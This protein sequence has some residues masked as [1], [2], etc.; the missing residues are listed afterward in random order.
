MS[1]FKQRKEKDCLNCGH[2]VEEHYCTHCGQE[3][4]EVKEDALHMIIHA[5]SDYFHFEHKFFATL[6]PLLTKPGELTKK[7]VTGKRVSYLHPIKLYIFVSI[8]FFLFVAVVKVDKKKDKS[9]ETLTSMSLD[10][11]SLDASTAEQLKSVEQALRFV[12]ATNGLRDSLIREAKAE[13][14]KDAKKSERLRD[15]LLPNTKEEASTAA[16]STSSREK[17]RRNGWNFA[18]DLSNKDTSVVQ[19][20][21]RQAALPEGQRDGFIKHYLVKRTIELN[22]LENPTEKFIESVLHNLPKGMFILLPLF[23]LILKLVYINKKRYYF[24]HLIYSFH[25]HTAIFLS[26]LLTMLLSWIFKFVYNLEAWLSFLCFI[27]VV[28]YIYRSLRTFYG[29]TRW[30]TVLKMCFL[31]FSYL[32]ALIFSLLILF[33]VS[34]AML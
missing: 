10:T 32:F 13:I 7:Y 33:T 12:P 14:L 24:E 22:N 1:G 3:N 18:N 15:S 27:Y 30:I 19:Y 8:L 26:I 5:V 21:Q 2:H 29:S 23:A 25:V 17:K 28:W 4:I 16:K 20:E 11:T 31:S 34:L 9:E 6:S